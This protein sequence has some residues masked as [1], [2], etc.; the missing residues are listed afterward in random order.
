VSV[1]FAATL[2]S[3]K[4]YDAILATAPGVS[5][6]AQ[7]D[8]TSTYFYTVTV[9]PV[10]VG[11][12]VT[13]ASIGLDCPGTCSVRV[14]G[15]SGQLSVGY[16][17]DLG[18]QFRAWT[19]TCASMVPPTAN[20]TLGNPLADVTLTLSADF[21]QPQ[22]LSIQTTGGAVKI[23]PSG[24]RCEG[25][26]CDGGLYHLGERVTL[27]AV[28]TPGNTLQGWSGDCASSAS[29]YCLL[30]M[31]SSKSVQATFV[32]ANVAFVAGP[33]NETYP[34]P[35]SADA[36][37]RAAAT[38]AGL[39]GAST[40]VSWLS[41]ADRVQ[42]LGWVRTDGKP[43]AARLSDL[44]PDGGRPQHFAY[45]IPASD[46]GSTSQFTVV[47]GTLASGAVGGTCT[48][49]AGGGPLTYG[50]AWFTSSG[51]T[52]YN[53]TTNCILGTAS[54]YC[55]GNF[56]GGTYRSPAIPP[57]ARRAFITSV[58]GN[59][60]TSTA[61]MDALCAAEAAD[62]GLS[63]TF[64]G[65]R[66]ET[67][68]TAASRFSL[69]GGGWFRT[70][71]VAYIPWAPD[72]ARS[73]GYYPAATLTTT[74]RGAPV[75]AG[76]VWTGYVYTPAG[77]AYTSCSDWTLTGGNGTSG[78]AHRRNFLTNSSWGCASACRFYCLEE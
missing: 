27:S 23:L 26:S 54:I 61:A 55:F 3:T 2:N 48:S 10:P 30:V 63:G 76:C 32:P 65:L 19:G 58:T 44:I 16:T 59:G 20:C 28:A 41:G 9:S 25:P 18:Y 73:A 17:A 15:T 29:D 33:W 38:D 69:D 53:T 52:E 43:I 77:L 66:S 39:P 72:L 47:T 57:G 22:T 78:E 24:A 37:C 49:W 14:P 64:L 6:S 75:P 5:V 67:T 71:G 7:V 50:D 8:G 40:Y 46:P 21:W 36:F 45:G 31:D 60:A 34:G 56:D 42:D 70:D 74:A 11:G 1:S 4:F 13:A 35:A 51:W 62:A 12:H 68:F